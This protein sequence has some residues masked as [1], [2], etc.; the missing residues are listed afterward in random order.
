MRLPTFI[1]QMPPGERKY[2]YFGIP[3]KCD[4]GRKG[5]T[6]SEPGFAEYCCRS[7]AET[8][9]HSPLCDNYH[10]QFLRYAK[11]TLD[12]G[13]TF[14]GLGG[15]PGVVIEVLP[16]GRYLLQGLWKFEG[17]QVILDSTIRQWGI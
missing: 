1:E 13:D 6:A 9:K 16:N 5:C 14:V 15:P 12:V 17:Q 4:C 10:A 7:C 2:H 11:E 3:C 8:G